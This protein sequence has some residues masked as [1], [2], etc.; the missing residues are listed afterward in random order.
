MRKKM[1]ALLIVAMVLTSTPFMQTTQSRADNG[2]SQYDLQLGDIAEYQGEG[3]YGRVS[4]DK[5][6]E[7]DENW[8]IDSKRNS[9]TAVDTQA[10]RFGEILNMEM[11]KYLRGQTS[12]V[13]VTSTD[14]GTQQSGF[15]LKSNVCF[16]FT[17]YRTEFEY[18]NTLTSNIIDWIYMSIGKYPNLA[19][20]FTSAS[21]QATTFPVTGKSYLTAIT[22]QSPVAAS[23]LISTTNQY[24][25]KLAELIHVPKHDATMT[26][27]EQ[28]LYIHDQLVTDTQYSDAANINHGITH[29]GVGA[30]LNHDSVCQGYA[31]AFEHAV[32]VLG[33]D[34]EYVT[35]AQ[36]AWNALLLDGKW[37]HLDATWDDPIISYATDSKPCL[38]YVDHDFFLTSYSGITAQ[39][40]GS[41]VGMHTTNLSAQST[42][43]TNTGDAYDTYFPRKNDIET[44]LSYLDGNWYYCENGRIYIW[45]GESDHATL[46]TEVSD[47]D[48][49]DVY[50]DTLYYANEDGVYQYVEDGED[51]SLV[52]ANVTSMV[53]MSNELT[54]ATSTSTTLDAYDL[55]PVDVSEDVADL[56]II[57][58]PS[59]SASSTTQVSQ[60]PIPE[61]TPEPVQSPEE[62]KQP[63]NSGASPTPPVLEQTMNPTST[64][65][66]IPS[67]NTEDIQKVTAGTVKI[68][69]IK[70]GKKKLSISYKK[71]GT[72]KGMQIVY[73]MDKKFKSGVKKKLTT[74][75]KKYV[76]SK[77]KSKKKYYVR[78]RAYAL[79]SQG[80]KVYG[81][82]SAVKSCKTK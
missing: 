53:I 70:K 40:T 47:A 33:Y 31:V 2:T 65:T 25:E 1:T 28:L 41:N 76:I 15:Q 69:S 52:T 29:T 62:T 63:A 60:S 7:S 8:Y 34:C 13:T 12:A 45:D 30:L 55:P 50:D 18:T 17:E 80:K 43:R 19:T 48:F 14:S 4:L 82:Y 26:E 44:Q 73:A 16:D 64:G 68:V 36:H 75:T 32:N 51:I 81:K 9:L 57:P 56:N 35:S 42:L 21:L 72:V 3:F 74:K 23:E 10:Q 38:E 78:I 59:P 71:T 58:S 79:D 66:D 24:K 11:G 49:C 46:M 37:Y 54:Y 39:D 20:L 22:I 6:I 67:D 5:I 77:L 61:V 27:E